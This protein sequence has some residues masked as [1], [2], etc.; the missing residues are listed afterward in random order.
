MECKIPLDDSLDNF[1]ILHGGSERMQ[2]LGQL[3]GSN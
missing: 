2:L 3:L 1:Q